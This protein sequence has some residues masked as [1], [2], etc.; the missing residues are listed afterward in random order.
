MQVARKTGFP[1]R[2]VICYGEH[3]DSPHAPVSIL[4][5]CIPDPELGQIYETLSI[6]ER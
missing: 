1:V 3:P 6:E 4:M 2:Q 5:T